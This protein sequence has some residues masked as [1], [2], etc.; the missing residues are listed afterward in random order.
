MPTATVVGTGI[1][2]INAQEVRVDL[3]MQIVNANQLVL[4]NIG[5][6]F[7]VSVEDKTLLTVEETQFDAVIA[8]RGYRRCI[9][10]TGV[11]TKVGLG[12]YPP[13]YGDKC[14]GIQG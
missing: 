7:D 5:A 8:A 4:H 6:V 9:H 10:I 14:T 11:S 13:R 1:V 12:P 3:M 2:G